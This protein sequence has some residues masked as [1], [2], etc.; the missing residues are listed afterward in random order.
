VKPVVAVNGR[1]IFHDLRALSRL[2]EK[3]RQSS[4]MRMRLG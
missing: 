3:R 2:H 1:A 4:K